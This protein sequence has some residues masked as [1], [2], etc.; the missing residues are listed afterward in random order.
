MSCNAQKKAIVSGIP[1]N[2]EKE[3]LVPVS[4]SPDSA[5]LTALFECDSNNQ[6]ILKAYNEFKTSRM[7]SRLSFGNSQLSYKTKVHTD[8]IYIPVKDSIIYLAVPVKEIASQHSPWK[9]FWIYGGYFLA[10]ILL[11]KCLPS[12]WKT[13][14]KWF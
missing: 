7:E 8:T 5:L 10:A 1:L 14:S 11:L 13:V 12:A 6:V 2:V 4:L 9:Q 3:R